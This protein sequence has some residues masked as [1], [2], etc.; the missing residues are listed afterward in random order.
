[1]STLTLFNLPNITENMQ[2]LSYLLSSSSR[3]AGLATSAHFNQGDATGIGFLSLTIALHRFYFMRQFSYQVIYNLSHKR[4][5]CHMAQYTQLFQI[6]LS[7]H[8][9]S[10]SKSRSKISSL[11]LSLFTLLNLPIPSLYL[12]L[13][14]LIST[15]STT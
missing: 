14:Q 6:R 13:K 5:D 15:L 2:T 12:F 4:P 7:I 1:M 9:S 3:S 11:L 8:N 10:R